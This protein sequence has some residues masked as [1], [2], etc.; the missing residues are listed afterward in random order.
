MGGDVYTMEQPSMEALVTLK[1]RLVMVCNKY[2]AASGTL[3]SCP[4]QQQS[5]GMHRDASVTAGIGF[6]VPPAT[7]WKRSPLTVIV[8]PDVNQSIS[9]K[10]T[11]TSLYASSLQS[12][13]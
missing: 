13:F 12:G 2:E 7:R 8:A 6:V 4:S 11:Q 5:R 1:S 9:N 3:K 10:G